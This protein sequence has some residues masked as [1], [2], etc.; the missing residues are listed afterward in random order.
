MSGD[1]R[2]DATAQ[3]ALDGSP[4]EVA[5]CAFLDLVGDPIRLTSAPYSIS[6]TGT[7]DPDLDGETFVAAEGMLMEVSSVESREG[8]GSTVTCTL[9]G[10]IPLDS[11]ILN[12][13]GDKSNWQGRT[14]RLFAFMAAADGSRTGNVWCF[15]T[16]YM[17]VPKIAGDADGQTIT[18]TIESWLSFMTQA[19]NRTWLAQSRYDADDLSA[20]ASIAIANSVKGNAIV[21]SAG[22]VTIDTPNGPVTVPAGMSFF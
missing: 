21:P 5:Y 7:G 10:M 13:I 4:H 16:G 3:A 2:P 14:A 6:F 12:T 11:D 9:S 15:Y 1:V 17:T 19:S 22:G 18:L 20:E 8:G